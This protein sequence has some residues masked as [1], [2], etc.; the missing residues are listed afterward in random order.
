VDL[1]EGQI[2]P[3]VRITIT[4]ELIRAYAEASGDFNPIHLD[5]KVAREAG[6]PSVIAHGM[7]A[8]CLT[9]RLIREWFSTRARLS[10]IKVRFAEMVF[11]GDELIFSATI[12]AV[13]GKKCNLD[14]SVQKLDS[15]KVLT[16]ANATVVLFEA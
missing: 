1:V 16:K 4:R 12:A 13:D 11:P 6:L 3:D 15:S 7:L 5:D 2:L 10:Y 9:M 14:L 8:M